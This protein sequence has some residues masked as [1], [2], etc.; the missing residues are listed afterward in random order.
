MRLINL[1][2]LLFLLIGTA[3]QHEGTTPK[4]T[5][6]NNNTTAESFAVDLRNEAILEYGNLRIYPVVGN[7]ALIAQHEELANFQSLGEAIA[8]NERFRITEKKPYGRF[9]DQGAVN[10]LTVQ[11]KSEQDVYLMAGDVVQ[12]GNQDRV[13]AEDI[14]VKA[15]S[16][17][18]IPVFC[19][20][21]GRWTPHEEADDNSKNKK[22]FAF[23]GYYNV[24]A[25]DIR[26]TVKHSKN[27]QEVWD[28]VGQLTSFHNAKAATGTY[29]ALENSTSF[30]DSREQ[31]LDY[32]EG[33]LAQDNVIGIVAISGNEI[34]GT[35]I[36]GHPDLFKKQYGALLYS[37]IT[38]AMSN[39]EAP[40]ITESKMNDYAA[41]LLKKYRAAAKDRDRRFEYNGQMVHFTDL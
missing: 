39:G 7:Q 38:E 17:T 22:I 27:Q 16:I 26:R 19:V 37:Y 11:N 9:S 8:S 33:K 5:D 35:D 6:V 2:L 40:S 25:N 12:G 24:A 23:N 28:K 29:A 4:T 15:G 3:C 10:T 14:L 31:Y 18:D 41:Q 36:F 13:I 32:F 20:E 1:A 21:K 34:I 30:T